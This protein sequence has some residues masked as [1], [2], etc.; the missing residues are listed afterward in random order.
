MRKESPTGLIGRI[1]YPLAP[2]PP[3]WVWGFGQSVEHFTGIDFGL[4]LCEALEEWVGSWPA[5]VQR[6]VS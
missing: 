3:V 6:K 2:S 1:C 4:T 5:A